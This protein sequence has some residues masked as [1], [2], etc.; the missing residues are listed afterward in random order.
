M[1]GPANMCTAKLIT[2]TSLPKTAIPLGAPVQKKE[3]ILNS[4]VSCYRR[5][6]ILSHVMG[7]L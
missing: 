5:M 6:V 1:D 3:N 7:T 2:Q 4:N